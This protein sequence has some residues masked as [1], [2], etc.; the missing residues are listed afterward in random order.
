MDQ[1]NIY[2]FLAWIAVA[3]ARPQESEELKTLCS[4]YFL[5]EPIPVL[6]DAI[7]TNFQI[8]ATTENLWKKENLTYK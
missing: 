1:K 2:F 3:F 8:N 6:T 4:S 5:G 7:K